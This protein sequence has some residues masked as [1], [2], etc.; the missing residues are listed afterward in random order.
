MS[1]RNQLPR[2]CGVSFVMMSGPAGFF[3]FGCLMAFFSSFIV[4]SVCHEIVH[5]RVSCSF[6]FFP[7]HFLLQA[8]RDGNVTLSCI[9]LGKHNSNFP[10]KYFSVL[11]MWPSAPWFFHCSVLFL[12]MFRSAFFSLQLLLFGSSEG[13]YH[14]V[15]L[16]LDTCLSNSG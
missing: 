13:L 11:Q 2:C 15:N 16:S 6:L 10:N 9:G 7:L 8:L 5:L 14:V 3:C 12:S 1:R 4:M